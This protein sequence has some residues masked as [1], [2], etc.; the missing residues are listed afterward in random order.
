MSVVGYVALI[1]TN[2]IAAND[3]KETLTWDGNRRPRR[4]VNHRQLKF[5]NEYAW[6][7]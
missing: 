1:S 6:A 7:P 2:P 5:T 3:H 4:S